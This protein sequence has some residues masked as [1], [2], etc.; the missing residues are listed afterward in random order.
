MKYIVVV[1]N[2]ISKIKN[3]QILFEPV[4]FYHVP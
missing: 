3:R 1:D 2:I 4:G